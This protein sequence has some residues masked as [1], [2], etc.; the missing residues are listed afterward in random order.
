LGKNILAIIKGKG[1]IPSTVNL[2]AQFVKGKWVRRLMT[3]VFSNGA[4]DLQKHLA[5]PESARLKAHSPNLVSVVQLPFRFDITAT[6]QKWEKFL[7]Q[8]LPDKDSRLL[9]Q[10]IFGYC[11][12]YDNSKQVF[13]CLVGSG[14][15]GKGVVAKVLTDM[16]GATNVSG[17]GLESFK[18]THGLEET[19]GKLVNIVPEMDD[20]WRIPEGLLKAFTGQDLISFNPKYKPRFSDYATARLIILTNRLPHFKDK[21]DGMLRRFIPLAFQISIPPEARNPNLAQEMREELPGILN[22]AIQGYRRLQENQHFTCPKTTRQ[23]QRE[24]RLRINHVKVFVEECCEVIPGE[25]VRT[26]DVFIEYQLFCKHNKTTHPWHLNHVGA[27]IK[28]LYP[29]VRRHKSSKGKRMYY[30]LGLR[31]KQ[32]ET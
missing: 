14:A 23:L 11:L 9:L 24:Y 1:T 27:K 16:L 17:L 4:L 8:V 32:V 3:L 13:F 5:Q 10:E 18:G 21:S 7:R 15:N 22:W 25:K 28:D 31:L 6:C 12:T 20:A 30:Y 2:P 19:L 29:D 26:R